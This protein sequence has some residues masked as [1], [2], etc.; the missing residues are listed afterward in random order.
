MQKSQ[1]GQHATWGQRLALLS[2][3]AG[4]ILTGIAWANK[5]APV[6]VVTATEQP[7]A[8][9]VPLTGTITSASSSALSPRVSG[10]VEE[11]HVDAGHRVEKGDTLI[12]LD[13]EL[14]QLALTRARAAVSEARAQL[15]ESI[16]LLREAEKLEASRNIPETQVEAARAEVAINRATLERL[17]SEQR[18]QAERLRRHTLIAPFAGVIGRKLT[19][20]GEWVDTGTTVLELVATN[21]LRLD[22]QAPQHLY[23]AI[24]EGMSVDVRVDAL[25]DRQ[26]EAQV[27]A[28]VPVNDPTARTFL[29]RIPLDNREQLLTPGMSAKASFRVF[30]GDRG[31][32][33][34]RDAIIRLPDGTTNVWVVNTE[35]SPPTVSR[36]QVKLGRIMADTVAIKAGLEA[37][38]Q[39]VV[40]GN[41]VLSDGQPVR[42]LKQD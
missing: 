15:D 6:T 33:L 27:G 26:F 3:F 5:T 29:V 4:L 21:R 17:Q 7:I 42:I 8:E 38:Q 14:A 34:P 39:V 35:P 13:T 25:P 10:L 24:G 20:A 30:T 37:G 16:R 36:K 41:E 11:V 32:V 9:T 22:V 40:R 23:T 31:L 18:E 28:R 1:P 19:E 12:Q 2:G